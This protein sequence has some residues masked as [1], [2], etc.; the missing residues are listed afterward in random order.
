M[1]GSKKTL[2]KKN[3]TIQFSIVKKIERLLLPNKDR[4]PKFTTKPFTNLEAI[5]E[6]VII[7]RTNRKKNLVPNQG[8]STK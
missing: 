7:H 8:T 5:A 3:M 1:V 4:L 6:T 2:E